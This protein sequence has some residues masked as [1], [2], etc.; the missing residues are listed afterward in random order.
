MKRS[1]YLC[2]VLLMVMALASP[3]AARP[4]GDATPPPPPGFPDL[5]NPVYLP[6]MLRYSAGMQQVSGQVTDQEGVPIAGATV[7]AGGLSAVTDANGVYAFS[8]PSGNVTLTPSLP[9]AMAA[10]YEFTTPN[11]SVKVDRDRLNLNFTAV[12]KK[13]LHRPQTPAACAF[14]FPNPGFETIFWWNPINGNSNGY[15]PI[16]ST[17]AAYTGTVSGFTGYRLGVAERNPGPNSGRVGEARPSL[18][19]PTPPRRT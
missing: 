16:Y 10:N 1:V 12:D 17:L 4:A 7:S 11:L 5:A 6:M 2:T 19:R 15:V 13:F 9:A 3:A 8:V 14:I 18:F